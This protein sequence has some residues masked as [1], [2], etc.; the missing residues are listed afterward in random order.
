MLI[1]SP[2]L[3]YSCLIP[4]L[5]KIRLMKVS[6]TFF[7]TNASRNNSIEEL[8]TQVGIEDTL[9]ELTAS[10]TVA[11]V[12]PGTGISQTEFSC[13]IIINGTKI[14]KLDA[15]AQYSK[16]QKHAGSTD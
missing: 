13:T 3:G 15:L 14:L 5:P 11:V 7:S 12:Q 1:S 8:E 2:H 9:Q 6:K 10:E 16:F 4:L